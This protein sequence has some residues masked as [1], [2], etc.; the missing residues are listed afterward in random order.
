MTALHE[1][2]QQSLSLLGGNLNNSFSGQ[3]SEILQQQGINMQQLWRPAID[4]I[5]TDEVLQVRMNLAGVSAESIDVDFFNNNVCIKG[6]RDSPSL[7][8]SSG[9]V[10]L[11]REIVYGKFERKIVLPISITQKESVAIEMENGILTII[12]DKNIE[13]SNKFSLKVTHSSNSESRTGAA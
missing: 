2:L 8:D 6:E 9:A 10:Q 5:E 12:I 13:N 11:R 7:S 4:I 3:L 1:L